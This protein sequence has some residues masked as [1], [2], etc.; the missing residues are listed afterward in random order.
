MPRLSRCSKFVLV[1][2]LCSQGAGAQTFA[3]RHVGD[4]AAILTLNTDS[5]ADFLRINHP[6]YRFCT[7]DVNGDG[8][9]EA[10]VGVIKK[11]RFYREE[12][13]RLFIYKNYHG[14]IRALWMGSRL[15][16]ILQD[17]R[18]S[19]GK[20]ISLETDEKGL[21][22]VA[23]YHWNTFGLAFDHF[24]AEQVSRDEALR[25]FHQTP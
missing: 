13:R 22:Y 17:F 9:Q 18:F 14:R 15:G 12:A 16:G 2:S 4:S 25:H 6:T 5:T 23:A 20:I 8:Q 21:F 3:L 11:T 10:I 1:L 7:G 19:N 24:I